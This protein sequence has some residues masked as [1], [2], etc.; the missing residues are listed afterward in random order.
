MGD[1]KV[2]LV[3]C[4]VVHCVGEKYMFANCGLQKIYNKLL[5]G[6]DFCK[7]EKKQRIRVGYRRL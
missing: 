2:Y 5:L 4:I 1:S 7:D 6:V 3:Y